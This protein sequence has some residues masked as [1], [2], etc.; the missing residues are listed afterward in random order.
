[1]KK[2]AMLFAAV[3]VAAAYIL[4][5]RRQTARSAN[6]SRVGA[7]GHRAAAAAAASLAS[8]AASASAES[9][10]YGTLFGVSRDMGNRRGV[11]DEGGV[12]IG[13]ASPE[14]V[15]GSVRGSSLEDISE[16]IT[17]GVAKGRKRTHH[18]GGYT[19]G[20]RRPGETQRRA[21]SWLLKRPPP[22]GT[23]GVKSPAVSV[24]AKLRLAAR[25]MLEQ[26]EE[27]NLGR[28][29]L[30][31]RSPVEAVASALAGSDG[32][33]DDTDGVG[34]EVGRQIEDTVS[35]EG[36]SG[37][38]D[39]S[40]SSFSSWQRLTKPDDQPPLPGLSTK[41]RRTLEEKMERR[42]RLVDAGTRASS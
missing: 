21:P 24:A 35:V 2:E 39:Q 28:R 25:R 33:D 19:K 18:T 9:R 17:R 27:G 23:S 12:R 36:S 26:R 40:A 29:R 42:R 41:D 38:N 30:R 32:S 7:S 16:N 10:A 4:E 5:T 34:V 11:G 14:S 31:R 37:H 8:L 15:F 1:M 20:L 22:A 3:A 13:P 6:R